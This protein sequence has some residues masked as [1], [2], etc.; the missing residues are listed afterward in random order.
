MWTLI[1]AGETGEPDS[2]HLT[3]WPH[4]V[5]ALIDR[6]L[7]SEVALAR[8]LAGLGRSARSAAGVSYRQPLARALVAADQV[9][10]LGAELLAQLAEELNVRA[11]EL[12]PAMRAAGS[13]R[14]ADDV[15]AASPPL[16]GWAAARDGGDTV[17][18][19]LASSPELR[20]EG[21]A[22]EAIGAIQDA[23]EADGLGAGDDIALCWQTA[24]PELASA[25]TGHELLVKAEVLA[26]S[27]V[28]VSPGHRAAAGGSEYSDAVI[29]LRFWICPVLKQP[30]P[31]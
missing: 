18:L 21:L 9:D 27:C 16:P 29:G 23:R 19:D 17:A 13:D 12:R 26:E 20:L 4:P 8:R 31:A 2:V 30:R 1:R 15:V 11:V 10:G 7:A 3:S 5:P 28:R 6:R 22:R 24:D 14:P 25:M